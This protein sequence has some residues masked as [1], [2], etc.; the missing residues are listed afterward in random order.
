MTIKS[1]IETLSETALDLV[2][3]GIWTGR[4][5]I[6]RTNDA[7]RRMARATPLVRQ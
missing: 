1:T 6:R 4:S 7:R 3:G 2:A 5:R